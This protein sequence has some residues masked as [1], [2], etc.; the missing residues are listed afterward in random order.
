MDDAAPS[1]SN[2]SVHPADIETVGATADTTYNKQTW[3]AVV[4]AIVGTNDATT[5][6][7]APLDVVPANAIVITPPPKPRRWEDVYDMEGLMEPPPVLV[8][9]QAKFQ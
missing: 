1:N 2:S 6:A 3:P 8:H 4:E 9:N 5:V 7:D